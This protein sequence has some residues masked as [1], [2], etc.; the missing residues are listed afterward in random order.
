MY[1]EFVIYWLPLMSSHKSQISGVNHVLCK[2][3]F[4]FQPSPSMDNL[5]ESDLLICNFQSGGAWFETAKVSSSQRRGKEA[6]KQLTCFEYS[7][8]TTL[9]DN[10]GDSGRSLCDNDSDGK[11][12]SLRV[13]IKKKGSLN[14]AIFSSKKVNSKSTIVGERCEMLG[15]RKMIPENIAL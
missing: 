4:R 3:T 15:F 7:I 8:S 11:I 12:Q 1:Y 14:C 9:L 13:N 6:G 5:S 2:V 10:G